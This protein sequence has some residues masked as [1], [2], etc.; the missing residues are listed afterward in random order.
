MNSESKI[1]RPAVAGTFYPASPTELQTTVKRI[2]ENGDRPDLPAPVAA[3][4][5]PHAGYVF[6]ARVAAP[7]YRAMATADFD[8]AVIIGHDFGRQA[9]G[10]TAILT[11][12]ETYE[13]P[14]GPVP[15]DVELTRRLQAALPT[16][17]IHNGVHAREHSIEVHL[18]FLQTLKPQAKILPV[19]FGE[20]TPENCRAFARA[21][22]QAAGTRKILILASTDL[23]HYP[24]YGDARELDEKT[25]AIIAALDLEGLCR[26]Q[27]GQDVD[28]PN[29]ETA[30]CSAGGV[31][32]AIAWLEDLTQPSAKILSRANS[33][34]VRGGD[35]TRVVGYA[36]AAFMGIPKVPGQ[37]QKPTATTPEPASPDFALAPPARQELLTLARRRLAA[38]LNGQAW[39]YR[40]PANLPELTT[41]AA[42][43]VTLTQHGR[44]RGCIGTTTPRTPLWQAVQE[45]AIAAAFEDPRFPAL[46][47]AEL[48]EVHIE[49]SVLSPMRPA[50]SA[51]DI[52]PGKHGV[53]IRRGPHSGLFLPQVWEQIPGRDQFL[54][55]LCQE[56]AGL[57][58]LAWKDQD[59]TLL[60]FT[61]F[62][63]E[64]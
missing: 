31:G 43:F 56:K 27:A 57:P 37:D 34:E 49:I 7:A 35:L 42:A 17:I 11:D 6:S 14:L 48:P 2:L 55:I 52:V 44:L 1:R 39:S 25:T 3:I 24:A 15:V 18:P 62:A 32:V 23:C 53:L 36:S 33:G 59:T 28:K 63:F 38:R 12:Y 46:E 58:P 13:T 41:R 19:L 9:R 50:P 29:T 54:S 60:V 26:R 45:M 22:R 40:P 10:I 20:A 16:V 47:A 21:L 8:T 64:E 30:I 61:V 5:A 4:M 51:A